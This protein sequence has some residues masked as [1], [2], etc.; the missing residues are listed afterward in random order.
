MTSQPKS[1]AR[2]V[3]NIT[4]VGVWI[5]GIVSLLAMIIVFYAN[6]LPQTIHIP[7]IAFPSLE[8]VYVWL[9]YV[10]FAWVAVGLVWYGIVR[11][12]SPHVA[13]ALGSRYE[14]PEEHTQLVG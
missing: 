13:E 12:R 10:F 14:R 1:Q 3:L 8:G 11:Y 5:A 4:A 9:P 2:T 7:G 6:W